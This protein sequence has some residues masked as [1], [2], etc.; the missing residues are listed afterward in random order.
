MNI[1]KRFWRFMSGLFRRNL[2]IN[3]ELSEENVQRLLDSKGGVSITANDGVIRLQVITG[4]GLVLNEGLVQIDAD[5]NFIY[6]GNKLSLDFARL[7]AEILKVCDK[8]PVPDHSTFH[9]FVTDMQF[10]VCGNKLEITKEK[11]T[12]EVQENKVGFVIGFVQKESVVEFQ[13]LQLP[14]GYSNNTYCMT[15]SK[16]DSK[17]KPNFYKL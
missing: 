2:V 7:I 6:H 8:E 13:E 10:R 14:D 9:Q 16:A 17:T 1:I 15:V 11:T 5:K 12:F 4:K 3:I